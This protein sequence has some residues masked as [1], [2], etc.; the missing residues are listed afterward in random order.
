[1]DGQLPDEWFRPGEPCPAEDSSCPEECPGAAA[2]IPGQVAVETIPASD[3]DDTTTGHRTIGSNAAGT[4]VTLGATHRRRTSRNRPSG[5]AGRVRGAIQLS[6]VLALALVVGLLLGILMTSSG[7]G[8]MPTPNGVAAGSSQT[9][10]SW[11]GSADEGPW[12]GNL[13]A[14]PVLA[15]SNCPDNRIPKAVAVPVMSVA[16]LIDASDAT[17]WGC[18]GQVDGL[19]V[20]F[21]IDKT[22]KL[23][24]MGIVNGYAYRRNDGTDLYMRFRR[25]LDVRWILPDGEVIEQHL[26]DQRRDEQRITIPPVWINGQVRM[27]IIGLSAMTPT[28]RDAVALSTVRLYSA[29]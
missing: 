8:Q 9:V 11:A 19:T 21:T 6:L 7:A 13:G 28:S 5:R 15:T 27:Q 16:N 26:V 10:A 1:M 23:A 14:I 24:G 4:T 3:L 29:A 2:T 25:A 17:A 22:T 20:T 18:E 12:T